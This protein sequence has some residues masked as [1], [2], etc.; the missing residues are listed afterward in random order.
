MYEYSGVIPANCEAKVVLPNKTVII[1]SG[2]FKF[3]I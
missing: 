2:A 3:V 1:K